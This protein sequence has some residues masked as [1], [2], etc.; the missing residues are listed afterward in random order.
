MDFGRN[1]QDHEGKEALTMYFCYEKDF[2]ERWSPVVYHEEKPRKGE[3]SLTVERSSIWEVPL[4]CIN[5]NGDPMFGRLME[6][7]RP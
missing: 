2:A 4:D 5:V 1:C 3:N 7:F 6:R